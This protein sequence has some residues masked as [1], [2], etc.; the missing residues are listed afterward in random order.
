MG[1]LQQLL[2]GQNQG[3]ALQL[4][5]S[6]PAT[7]APPGQQDK[8]SAAPPSPRSLRAS[9]GGAL[10]GGV[11]KLLAL[12]LEV[13]QLQQSLQIAQLE[14]EARTV[15][16]LSLK[17]R[18]EQAE[19]RAASADER[20][21]RLG[22]QSAAAER[23]AAEL[24][25]QLGEVAARHQAEAVQLRSQLADAA[26]RAAAAEAAAAELRQAQASAEDALAAAQREL[27]EAAA[28]AA[29]LREQ[30]GALRQDNQQLRVHVTAACGA[31]K[32]LGIP[33]HRVC[34]SWLCCYLTLTAILVT[35]ESLSPRA[36]RP[37]SLPSSIAHKQP[38]S[39]FAHS[40]FV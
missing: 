24:R 25:F 33:I 22:Q 7:A 34:A 40:C 26:G 38:T 23:A 29:E 15:Q 39:V 19:Q 9:G 30:A 5:A 36:C 12:E 3:I 18:A 17:Q 4:A 35:Q 11:E 14:F 8:L 28:A 21:A 10:P 2:A 20:S 32:A 6:N 37:C 1:M 16:L 27:R 31:L 13:V